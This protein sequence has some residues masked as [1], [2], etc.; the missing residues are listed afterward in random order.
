MT[1]YFPE[2]ER[3]IPYDP[4]RTR[5]GAR[6]RRPLA[7]R[8]YQAQRKIRGQTMECRLKFAMAYW[9]TLRGAGADPFGLDAVYDR[10]WTRG[11]SPLVAAKHTLDAAFELLTKL[12]I[13]YYCFHDRD[14]SPEGATPRETR[15]NLERMVELAADRQEQTGVRLLWATANLFSH[16]RYTHGAATNPDPRVFA[17]AAAQVRQALDATRRLGGTGFVFWGGREGYTSL[18]HTDM[19][20]E[21]EQLAAFLHLAVDYAKSS[22]FEGQLFLEPKAREPTVHQYDFDCAHCLNFL[23]E[24]DLFD[25]FLLNV[26]AN[27]A[28]LAGHSFEHELLTAADAGKLGSLDINRGVEGV[29]W[30]TDNFPVDLRECVLALAVVD[31]AGGLP[32][33][34]LNFDA[35]VRRGSFRPLDL[36]FAHVGA[37][38]IFARALLVV[39][40]M[41]ADGI[42]GRGGRLLRERYSGYRRGV[43]RRI[44]RGE[45][46]LLEIEAWAERVGE[47]PLVSGR[48][49]ELETLLNDYLYCTELD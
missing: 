20:Q 23:R 18:I 32:W 25:H 34:G 38:D 35:K 12:G 19:Q 47:P 16:P 9:H 31:H 6:T 28:T 37:M 42:L 30:D 44:L 2:V 21:R 1:E 39:E 22:G 17:Q 43:G 15:R 26:E 36:F 10:D 5:V 27:H 3:P 8:W 33:G 29:G 49:E 14:L 41:R 45:M 24:F 11:D 4:Q 40:R 13:R 46:S 7:F 48:Q